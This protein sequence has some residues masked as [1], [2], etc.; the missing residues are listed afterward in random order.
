[1]KLK[2]L[3]IQFIIFSLFIVSVGVVF[4]APA[5]EYFVINE[6]SKQCGIYWPGDEFSQYEL[7]FGWKIYEPEKSLVLKTPFGTCNYKYDNQDQYCQQCCSELGFKYVS[8]TNIPYTTEDVIKFN[9]SGWKCSP[10]SGK[11]YYQ[12]ILVNEKNKE[13]TTLIG[14][15]LRKPNRTAY[16]TEGQCTITD[17]NWTVYEYQEKPEIY[18]YKIT[19]PF[20]ECNNLDMDTCCKQLGLT[21]MGR[22]LVAT[23]ENITDNKT[24]NGISEDRN[25]PKKINRN[26]YLAIIS[27]LVLLVTAL[28]SGILLFRKYKSKKNLPPSSAEPNNPPKVE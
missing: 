2:I 25:L 8:Y 21:N 26:Y 14:F 19:T 20:G 9:E 5:P 17:K 13:C 16:P 27:V 6:K 10:R 1:M 15:S 11:D 18:E 28:V 23:A 24:D 7:P 4:A 3:S 12:G 22:N